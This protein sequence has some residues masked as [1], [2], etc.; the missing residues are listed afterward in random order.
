[1]LVSLVKGK[2]LKKSEFVLLRKICLINSSRK[3]SRRQLL[4]PLLLMTDEEANTERGRRGDSCYESQYADLGSRH[5]ANLEIDTL[6]EDV[7][8]LSA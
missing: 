4:V 2:R 1:M 6:L 5:E 3:A 7:E 8:N